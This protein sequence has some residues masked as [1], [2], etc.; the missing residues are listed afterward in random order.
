MNRRDVYA[1][2]EAAM[3]RY[4]DYC[5]TGVR[6]C[7]ERLVPLT[8]PIEVKQI[9]EDMLPIT[10]GKIFVRQSVANRLRKAAE[11]LQS[12]DPTLYL[13][14]VYGYRTL[15]IQ[16]QLYNAERKKLS[17]SYM[18][19]DLI[20]RTHRRVAYPAVA[21]HPTGGAVDIQIVRNEKPLDFGTKIWDL[22][23]D[24]YVFSPFISKRAQYNR[25]LLRSVMLGVG[26][27]PFDG[28]WWHFSYGDKEWANITKENMR[29]MISSRR[30]M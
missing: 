30:L 11:A 21:G 26:F 3:L 16:K 10:G 29:Y 15:E 9:G 23:K 4:T 24:S 14:V 7:G 8:E 22:K 20:E 18:G 28:E 5:T 6:D 27:A 17:R 1:K 13:Q 25:Q 19:P 2:I 12:S